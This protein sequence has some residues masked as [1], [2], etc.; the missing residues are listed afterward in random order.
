LYSTYQ[1]RKW[2]RVSA[3]RR[4]EYRSVSGCASAQSVG[5]EKA[6]KNKV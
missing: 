5:E 6:M 2:V 3:E 1:S 4:R